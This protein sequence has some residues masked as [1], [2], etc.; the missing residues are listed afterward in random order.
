[1]ETHEVTVRSTRVLRGPNLYAY[2]PV[3]HAVIDIGPYEERP[4][5]SFP[6][7]VDR[8]SA[9]LPGLH[10]HECGVGRPGGFVERLRRGTYLAHIAEHITLELQSLM[11][12]DVAFGRARGAGERGVYNVVFAYKEEAPALAAFETALRLTLAAMHDEPFDM[13]SELDHLLTLADRYRLGPSTAA[14]VAAA[15]ARDIPV[16]RLTPTGSLV[17]LG[18]GIYQKRILASETSNTSSIAVD[19]CQEK[20]LTNQMLRAVGV[21]VPD[22]RVVAA[23]NDAWAAAPATAARSPVSRWTRQSTWCS[24]SRG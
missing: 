8:I 16:I 18:Y 21:P 20:S 24:S 6:D 2:M 17:Q 14:I 1:M 3:A 23:A 10:K 11:G 15:R 19:L 5:N 22:G 4:S 9:W 7:F 12:F 13:Q